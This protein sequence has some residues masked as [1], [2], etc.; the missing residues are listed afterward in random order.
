MS[1]YQKVFRYKSFKEK[2]VHLEVIGSDLV[3]QAYLGNRYSHTYIKR[4]MEILRV[5]SKLIIPCRYVQN[6]PAGP[7]KVQFSAC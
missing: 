7:E 3:I 4:N 2:I 6:S 5:E 1:A